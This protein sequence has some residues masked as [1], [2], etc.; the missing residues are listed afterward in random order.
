MI[1]L[2]VVTGRWTHIACVAGATSM[3]FFVDGVLVAELSATTSLS[4]DATDPSLIGANSPTGNDNFI[5][6][7]DVLQIYNRELDADA[8]CWAAQP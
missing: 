4:T 6:A 8:I 2:P 5:G 1:A 3:R 7:I